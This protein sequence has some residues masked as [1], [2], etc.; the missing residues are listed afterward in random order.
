MKE[1]KAYVRANVVD[2]VIDALEEQPKSPGL[3][4]IE[5][6]GYGHPKGGGPARLTRRIKL[7]IVVADAQVE[8]VLNTIV[9][10]ARTGHFGDGKIFVSEVT[11]AVRIR[12]SERGPA[13]VQFPEA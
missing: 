9:E 8:T 5:V 13:A 10:Q 7:E 2:D 3:T 1:I 6:R 11:E 4:A 12:T